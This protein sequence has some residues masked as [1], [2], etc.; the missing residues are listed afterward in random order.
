MKLN[1]APTNIKSMNQ[2]THQAQTHEQQSLAHKYVHRRIEELS[3]IC[4]KIRRARKL[5]PPSTEEEQDFLIQKK[6][7][8]NL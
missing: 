6:K 5:N 7:K 2:N 3:I 8:S 4:K 1:I